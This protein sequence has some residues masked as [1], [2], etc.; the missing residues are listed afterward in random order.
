MDKTE[1][2]CNI[3]IK[4]YKNYKSLCKHN[5]R[6]HKV[7]DIDNIDPCDIHTNPPVNS[8]ITIDLKGSTHEN[9]TN[10]LDHCNSDILHKTKIHSKMKQ[11]NPLDSLLICLLE[12]QPQMTT[13]EDSI[14]KGAFYK[15]LYAIKIIRNYYYSL[16]ISTTTYIHDSELT[17][18]IANEF[19]EEYSNTCTNWEKDIL[20]TMNSK[21]TKKFIKKRTAMNVNDKNE[22]NDA[23]KITKS[24]NVMI[25]NALTNTHAL[26][27]ANTLKVIKI[28][29]TMISNTST[30]T[31]KLIKPDIIL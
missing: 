8:N 21:Y 30:D 23:M 2:K 1:Y 18:F 11:V 3:C 20:S 14:L 12:M 16:D 5:S 4:I 19:V 9:N 28:I 26:T 6:F 15:L 27:D 7:I 25:S 24:I 13:C 17:Y 10:L 31:N 29:N 22:A